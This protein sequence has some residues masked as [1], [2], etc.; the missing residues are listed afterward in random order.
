MLSD[1]KSKKNFPLSKENSFF[2]QYTNN[3]SDVSSM[4][5]EL[6]K[7]KREMK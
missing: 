3:F 4:I 1:N 5:E 7:K 2:K 6:V